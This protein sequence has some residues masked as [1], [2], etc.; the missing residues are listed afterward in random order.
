MS[1]QKGSQMPLIDINLPPGSLEEAMQ[2]GNI[3]IPI[4][5]V[6]HLYDLAIQNFQD[7]LDSERG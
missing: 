3:E 2:E 6:H 7:Y 4:H 5:E 1:Y